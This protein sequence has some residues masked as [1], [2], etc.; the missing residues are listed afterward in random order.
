VNDW[1]DKSDQLMKEKETELL[2]KARLNLPHS[3]PLSEAN[4]IVLP[5]S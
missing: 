4:E 5:S 1:F 2:D 3:D